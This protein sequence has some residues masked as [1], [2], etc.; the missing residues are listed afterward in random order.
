MKQ[1]NWLTLVV[2]MLW[3]SFAFSQPIVH[4]RGTKDSLAIKNQV[5]LYLKHLDVREKIFLSVLYTSRMPENLEGFT[6]CGENK[7]PNG[8]QVL[9]VHI[10]AHQRKKQ[11]NLI[12]AHEMIHVKQYAKGELQVIKQEVIWQGRK[13]YQWQ[14]NT[15]HEPWEREAYKRDH[16]LARLYKPVPETPLAATS[17]APLQWPVERHKN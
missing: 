6:L 11:Q 7:E 5:F 1:L 14:N 13:R 3:T 9:I 12:L 2:G 16:W 15:K 17:P 4:I 8:Y 10:D